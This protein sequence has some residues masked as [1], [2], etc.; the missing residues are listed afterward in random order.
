[1]GKLA[2]SRRALFRARTY[3][4]HKQAPRVGPPW[5]GGWGAVERGGGGWVF[6]IKFHSDPPQQKVCVISL[7]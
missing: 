1:M 6:Y 2:V 7:V 5:Y 3:Y 4:P